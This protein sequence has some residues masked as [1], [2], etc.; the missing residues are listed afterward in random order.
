MRLL[1]SP[2]GEPGGGQ[3]PSPAPPPQPSAAPDAAP[4][5]AARTVTTG[6]RTEREIQLEAELQRE[7]DQHTSTA[8][9]KKQR[10]VRIA[11]LEDELHRLKT[12][13]KPA[14]DRGDLQRFLDG[15]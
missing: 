7:R 14:D 10:E 15:D 12:P 3:A 11:E 13:A 6:Q 2:D 4:P 1:L 5:A 8:A 9:E